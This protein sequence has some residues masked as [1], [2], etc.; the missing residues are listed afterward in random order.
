M[1]EK[2]FSVFII[3][4]VFSSCYAQPADVHPKTKEFTAIVASFSPGRL[5]LFN[6]KNNYTYYHRYKITAE[7]RIVGT[8]QPG[9]LAAV[10]YY[11]KKFG[12]SHFVK[13]AVRVEILPAGQAPPQENPPLQE[14]NLLYS[15]PKG[16]YN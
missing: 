13:I 1:K 7:T 15:N 8:I 9:A 11:L 4:L 10:T 3:V 5:M 16:G 14:K 6:K 12:S 2:L